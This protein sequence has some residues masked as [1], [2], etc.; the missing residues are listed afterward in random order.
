MPVDE[1]RLDNW[2]KAAVDLYSKIDTAYL[3]AK[4][5]STIIYNGDGV[6]TSDVKRKHIFMYPDYRDGW[7]AC[8]FHSDYFFNYLKKNGLLSS[9]YKTGADLQTIHFWV[10][11]AFEWKSRVFAYGIFK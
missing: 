10:A 11:K 6:R 3:E 5:S 2:I 1:S 9:L 4:Q 7:F 8:T